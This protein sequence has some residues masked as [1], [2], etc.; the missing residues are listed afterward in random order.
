MLESTWASWVN[1][2]GMLV[3]NAASLVSSSDWLGNM[4][5]LPGCSSGLLENMMEKLENRMV[6]L[7][8]MTDLT[9]SMM[10][11]LV[12][13]PEMLESSL[14]KL[15]STGW[16][17][18]RMVTSE[19]K[20]DSRG[21]MLP[22]ES[23]AA[24]SANTKEMLGCNSAMSGYSWDSSAS[25]SGWLV[26]SSDLWA[27]SLGSLESNL[28]KHHPEMQRRSSDCSASTMEMHSGMTR[29]TGTL[30]VP[31]SLV[32]PA[33]VTTTG[34]FLKRPI[35]LMGRSL[36]HRESYQRVV[37]TETTRRSLVSEIAAMESSLD[38]CLGWLQVRRTC[39]SYP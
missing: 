18:S 8:N 15:G 25:I 12:S 26:S 19:S 39:Q 21:H 17:A 1:S 22:L 6:T 28:E 37:P 3:S 20:P 33:L 10:D 23:T 32:N 35:G 9:A 4:M 27:N 30:M 36:V 7:E 31:A 29:S 2:W 16:S 5:E 24:M 38:S 11:S 13:K 14:G 34:T